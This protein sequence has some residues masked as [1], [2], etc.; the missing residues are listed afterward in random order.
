MAS[1][2]GLPG[3]RILAATTVEE[4]LPLGGLAQP[5][6]L[7]QMVAVATELSPRM[8]LD[9]LHGIERAAGRERG[10]RWESRTL[11]LDLVRHG[12]VVLS[13]PDLQLPHPGLGSRDFWQRELAELNRRLAS[14][15]S[16]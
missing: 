13:E 8:L 5:P 3:T 6:Y 10:E 9:A 2:G 7:N 12:S 1:I 4:T 16:T 11:D 14:V 15:S